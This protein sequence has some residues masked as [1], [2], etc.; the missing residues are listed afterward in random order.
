M[1]DADQWQWCRKGSIDRRDATQMPTKRNFHT[2][3]LLQNSSLLK[4]KRGKGPSLTQLC[5]GNR[6]E[7]QTWGYLHNDYL[8]IIPLH[9]HSDPSPEGECH[10]IPATTIFSG[11]LAPCWFPCC[12][13]TDW[14]GAQPNSPHSFPPPPG[15][16]GP[17]AVVL[18]SGP[19]APPAQA[20]SISPLLKIPR[21]QLKQKT[22]LQAPY[23][24]SPGHKAPC[25]LA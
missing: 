10:H 24:S 17:P 16:A 12:T 7:G 18:P 9:G 2:S 23:H 8:N 4:W 22:I 25:Q 5:V 20:T 11:I 21:N 13:N 1:G 14:I 6:H 3:N 15:Q 19:V